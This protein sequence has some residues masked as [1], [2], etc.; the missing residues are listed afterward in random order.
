M[1][2]RIIPL[3]ISILLLLGSILYF[4]AS[5][6]KSFVHENIANDKCNQYNSLS[7]LYISTDLQKAYHYVQHAKKNASNGQNT[8]CKIESYILLGEIYYIKGYLHQSINKYEI[9][10]ELISTSLFSHNDYQKSKI[11]QALGINYELLGEFIKSKE[12]YINA[13]IYADKNEDRTQRFSVMT[14]IASLQ[15]KTGFYDKSLATLNDA[16]THFSSIQNAHMLG[17]LNMQKGKLFAERNQIEEALNYFEQAKNNFIESNSISQLEQVHSH[18]ASTLLKT[19]NR[20]KIKDV[21]LF[22]NHIKDADVKNYHSIHLLATYGMY[23]KIIENNLQTALYYLELA[24]TGTKIYGLSSASPDLLLHLAEVYSLLGNQEQFTQVLNAYRELTNNDFSMV[25]DSALISQ[26]S[27]N[28]MDTTGRISL[29]YSSNSPLLFLYSL[30][31]LFLFGIIFYL[32]TKNYSIRSYWGSILNVIGHN[33]FRNLFAW[34]SQKTSNESSEAFD[35]NEDD[36]PKPSFSFKKY[37]FQNFLNSDDSTSTLSQLEYG[38]LTEL[39]K[40]KLLFN[41]LK[42]LIEEEELYKNSSLTISDLSYKIG[43][44]DKYI[45]VAINSQTDASFTTF[46]NSYRVE[47]AKKLLLK[48]GIQSSAKK[49]CCDAG[50]GAVST[51]HRV[52]KKYTGFSPAEWVRKQKINPLLP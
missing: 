35:L 17:V 48:Y 27:S 7:R 18:L 24:Y 22:L 16:Y 5:I 41:E 49:I 32:K 36:I 2:I 46:I 34:K 14:N 28:Q 47:Y 8:P 40:M 3:I 20:D 39:E 25:W 33:K 38:P 1:E 43:S 13:L 51:Y 11:W 29:F 19:E 52:F 21:L 50:F 10:L 44:N 30:V 23:Y 4:N 31:V 42:R 9:A 26:I 45:S 37:S 15:M 6:D 12:A